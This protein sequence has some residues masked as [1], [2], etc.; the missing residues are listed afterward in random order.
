MERPPLPIAMWV[1]AL[2]T[3]V[4]ARPHHTA[5]TLPPATRCIPSP[6]VDPAVVAEELYRAGKFVDAAA[7]ATEL[8]PQYAR[9]ARAWAIGMDP[10]A[11]PSDALLALRE[12]YKLDLVLGGAFGD[13]IIAREKVVAPR[14]VD[15]SIANGDREAAAAAQH[16][17]DTLGQ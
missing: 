4:L 15:E 10:T 3:L 2:A 16:V 13:Q 12:A 9:L 11:R 14:A 17:V 1:L 8:A 5:E 6:P 7:L